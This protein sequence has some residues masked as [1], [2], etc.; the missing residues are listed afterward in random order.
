MQTQYSPTDIEAHWSKQWE[1]QGHFQPS[2]SGEAYAIALPP[3]N[4]TGTLHMGHGFQYSLMD[5]LIR[6]ARM[7]GKNTLWQPGTDHAGIAT[8]MVVERQLEQQNLTRHDLGREPFIEKIWQ[9][10]EQSGSTI[11]HQMRRLGTSMDWSR[12]RFSMDDEITHATYTAFI[13]L[14]EDG[15]IYRG[16]RLV[17]WD[18]KLN[19]AISDLEVENKE[20]QGHLWHFK[21]PLADGSGHLTVATT[22]PETMLG[23]TAVAVH[24]DDERYQHLIGKRI[25]L[26]FTDREIPIIAD[27]YVDKEFGSGC[28]KITPAHDFN[29]NEIGKRHDLPLINVMTLDGRLNDDVPEAYRG[30]ERFAARK[31]IIADFERAG[32]L[33]KIEDHT[34]SIPYGARSGAIIEPL[35]TDQWFVKA[36]VLAKPAIEAVHQGKLDFVPDNWSKTYLQWLENIQDWCISRQLWWGHRI[37]VW[38]DNTGATYVGFDEAD[39][40]QRHQLADDLALHQDE[41]VFDTWFTAALWPFS[42]LGWPQNTEALKTFYP[43]QVLVTGF[44]IIFFWVA[45]MVMMGLYFLGDVPFKEV[46]ITGLIRDSHGQ[47]MSKS[48]GNVLDPIDLI[49]GIELEPLI[50]KRTRNLMQPKLKDKIIKQTRKEFPD[51]ISAH[52]TDALR[53]TFC[54]LATTGRDINFDMGRIEGYRNFCNKL[55][56]AT[57]FVLM[58]TEDFSADNTVNTLSLADRW[59][60]S[61]FEETIQTVNEAFDRYRFDLVA[62]ALYE[63]TWNYYCDWYLELA[64]CTLNNE[65]AS[66]TERHT[67]QHTLLTILEQ[68]CRLMHPLM[69]FITEEIWQTVADKCALKNKSSVMLEAYPEFD[70]KQVDQ[71]ALDE[72][73]WLQSFIT[74]IRNL[75]SEIGISPARPIRLILNHVSKEDQQRLDHCRRYIETL[76]KVTACDALDGATLPLTASAVLNGLEIHIPLEGLI[77]KDAEL[78]RLNREILKLQKDVDKSTQ[79]LGNTSYTEKA[80]AA[81]VEKEQAR[82]AETTQA[83]Q[84]LNDYA[85]RIAAL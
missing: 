31:Q 15:L 43:T 16:K 57:R 20:K 14:Y 22:R 26:P 28:V 45:R 82:L 36:D 69:P 51:G 65:A 34:N 67:T 60:I 75:R 48:K 41:D 54:A 8:Q 64:K 35:L 24:P 38:Y 47:K 1:S 40:R 70:S 3:P 56:N 77:D 62:T 71:D 84:K 73:A 76:V 46:Y 7:Q 17:N 4:V 53:F 19:T 6:R 5:A 44:D 55:W 33:E 72:M 25:K 74:I 10:R 85:T 27:D 37:P 30:L 32:L 78:A 59:I 39:A 21:Y 13:K 80:P 23:D 9:W 83:L 50:E 68:L 2:D 49:D 79:K 66:A 42:S 63:F 11:T 81:V 18:P 58:N 52:G 12:L 29:D 61:A